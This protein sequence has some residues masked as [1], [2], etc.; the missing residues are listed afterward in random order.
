[1]LCEGE[2]DKLLTSQYGFLA[3]TGTTGAGT[4]KP[5]WKKYFKGRDVVIIYDMDPGGRLG[6]ENVARALQGIASSIKNIELPVKGIKTDKDISDYFLK[7][8][9]N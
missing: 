3:V 4:F 2:F 6:A 7:H 1:I 9:A 5:E 8:G